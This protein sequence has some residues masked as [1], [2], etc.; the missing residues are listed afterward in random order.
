MK[1]LSFTW[2]YDLPFLLVVAALLVGYFHHW[3][4]NAELDSNADLVGR[5]PT[6]STKVV[7]LLALVCFVCWA[8]NFPFWGLFVVLLSL[9]LVASMILGGQVDG[10]LIGLFGV[11]V[12]LREWAFGFPS[13]ILDP[14]NRVIDSSSATS[15]NSP[16]VGKTGVALSPLRPMGDIEIEGKVL[17]A[18]SDTGQLID[19]G[20]N[21]TIVGV[22]N[23]QPR[24]SPTA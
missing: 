15:E 8:G 14:K 24:V 11:V 16:L 18:S 1:T 20:A 10:S 19:A 7:I 9:G 12:M 23:G 22:R 13:L 3:S 5:F 4:K 6:A 21:V 2:H 17:S